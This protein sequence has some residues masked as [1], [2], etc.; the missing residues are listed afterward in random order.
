MFIAVLA[1][2]AGFAQATEQ[3]SSRELRLP[4]DA[5]SV[6]HVKVEGFE[7]IDYK[8]VRSFPPRELIKTI[9]ANAKQ[10]G[11]KPLRDSAFNQ[12]ERSAYVEGW[13]K[14]VVASNATGPRRWAYIGWS[15]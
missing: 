3:P 7:R 8:L 11:W 1:I 12:D 9:A 2:V 15:Q 10:H 13:R 6:K 5:T 4:S 14:R